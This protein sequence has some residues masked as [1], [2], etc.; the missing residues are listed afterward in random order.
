[1]LSCRNTFAPTREA[2]A[3]RAFGPS[4]SLIPAFRLPQPAYELRTKGGWEDGQD[5]PQ[6]PPDLEARRADPLCRGRKAR[7]DDGGGDPRAREAPRRRGDDRALHRRVA[8]RGDPGDRR[9]AGGA[10]GPDGPGPGG[11]PE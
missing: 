11:E 3:S 7:R 10:R 6:D 1:M 5:R 8:H 4:P 2:A 9:G